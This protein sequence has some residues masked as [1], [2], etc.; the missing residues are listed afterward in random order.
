M[1]S[2]FTQPVRKM[3]TARSSLGME[4]S[5]IISGK[6]HGKVSW[7]VFSINSIL[8]FWETFINLFFSFILSSASFCN[9]CG[10]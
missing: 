10:K 7:Q 9:V 2:L 6:Q 1:Q 8:G 4:I 3:L 5:E